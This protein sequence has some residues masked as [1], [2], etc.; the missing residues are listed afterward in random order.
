ML[1]VS[2]FLREQRAD[3]SL[4]GVLV[5]AEDVAAEPLHDALTDEGEVRLGPRAVG[6]PCRQNQ[7]VLR[8]ARV[9]A[10]AH[11]GARQGQVRQRAVDERL[12]QAEE[13][14]RLREDVGLA[15]LLLE[16]RDEHL[17]RHPLDFHGHAGNDGDELPAPIQDVSPGR[18]HGVAERFGPLW[19]HGLLGVVVG[20]AEPARGEALPDGLQDGLV[21]VE[22]Q[23]AVFR[24]ALRRDVVGRG[25]QPPGDDDGVGALQDEIQRLADGPGFVAHGHRDGHVPAPDMKLAG[26]VGRVGVGDAAAGQFVADCKDTDVHFSLISSIPST[27][28]LQ[29]GMP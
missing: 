2:F 25:A 4:E 22:R 18:P 15:R 27:P 29:R 6:A 9:K 5:V 16:E 13:L 17:R 26:E 28:L 10:Q 7:V 19:E 24:D 23:A 12:G 11:R 14:D 21:Q 1:I 3:H 20:P 8:K